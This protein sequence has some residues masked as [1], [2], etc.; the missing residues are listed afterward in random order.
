MMFSRRKFLQ[1]SGLSTLGLGFGGVNALASK[2]GSGKRFI[3]VYCYGGWDPTRVFATEFD[4]LLVD[5]ERDAEQATAGVSYVSHPDR[6][7]VDAFFKNHHASTLILNGVMVPSIAHESCMKLSLTGTSA[8]G[9]ADWPAILAGHDSSAYSLPHLVLD[10]PSFPGPLGYAVTRSGTSGQLGGLISGDILDWSDI[11]VTPPSANAEAIMDQYLA[12]RAQAL[13]FVDGS[14]RFTEMSE[15]FITA[16]DRADMLKDLNGVLDWSASTDLF[17]Q[18]KMA[19]DVLSLGLSRCITMSYSGQGWDSHSNNDPT[20]SSNF[21]GLFSGLNELMSLLSQTN[22]PDGKALAEDTVVVVM[23]EMGRTPALNAQDGKDHWPYSSM[24][25]VGP[26]LTGGRVVGG[27]DSLYYGNL[28]D[29]S[30]AEIAKKGVDL[31]YAGVG[32]TLLTMADIDSQEWVPGVANYPG[33]LS[34]S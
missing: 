26:G 4:N 24:M 32:A 11:P 21:E 29:P 28:V 10:G 1:L 9:V 6:P 30:T 27:F 17:A 14:S 3:F 15:A 25:L 19:A 34:S 20:Q 31:T 12:K 5:M 22:G 18:S 16:L 2:A 8:T 13:Q 23:S 7:A 33:L